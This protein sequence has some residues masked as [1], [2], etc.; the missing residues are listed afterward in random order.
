MADL[1]RQ[2]IFGKR[3]FFVP[4]FVIN[5]GAEAINEW[6]AASGSHILES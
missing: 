6:D 2:V 5:Q 4:T 3:N 1:A